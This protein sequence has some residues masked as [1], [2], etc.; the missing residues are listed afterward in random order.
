MAKVDPREKAGRSGPVRTSSGTRAA[1]RVAP[2]APDVTSLTGANDVREG[3][4]VRDGR[5]VAVREE[6]PTRELD[7]EQIR[8]MALR[9]ASDFGA[10]EPGLA[11]AP[12]PPRPHLELVLVEEPDNAPASAAGIDDAEV[13]RPGRSAGVVAAA[14]VLVA[15]AI[16]T[17]GALAVYGAFP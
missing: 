14:I 17:I 11:P 8:A 13:A 15:L 12:S 9:C 3:P 5:D 4:D 10:D 1:V 2:L 7:L 6:M 16:A